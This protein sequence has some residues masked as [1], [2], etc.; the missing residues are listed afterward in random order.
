MLNPLFIEMPCTMP[1]AENYIFGQWVKDHA[2]A[3]RGDSTNRAGFY[4]SGIQN[5]W[6][7]PDEV[8]KFENL[9]KLPR[10][11]PTPKPHPE[12]GAG[13]L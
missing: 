5:G 13:Q 8:R 9:P 12:N 6:L 4:E 11:F 2:P 3:Q 10:K 7:T 1:I